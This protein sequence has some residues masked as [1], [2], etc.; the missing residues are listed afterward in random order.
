M[1]TEGVFVAFGL[2]VGGLGCVGACGR[3]GAVASSRAVG[4]RCGVRVG[5]CMGN[6]ERESERRHGVRVG[7]CMGNGERES[8]RRDGPPGC[9][10]G[11]E[12]E[13]NPWMGQK[14]QHLGFQ[15]GPP[16]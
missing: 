15:R 8:E 11:R 1:K 9:E 5:T 12:R 16:P 2:G 13:E 6:G 4:P 3:G 14:E 7:M 10:A